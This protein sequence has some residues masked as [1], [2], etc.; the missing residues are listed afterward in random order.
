MS[1]TTRILDAAVA[2]GVKQVIITASV[3]SL[4][5]KDDFWKEITITE[6]CEFSK[7]E[8]KGGIRLTYAPYLLQHTIRRRQKRRSNPENLDTMSTVSRRASRMPPHAIS[9]AHTQIWT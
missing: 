6:G 7:K 5:P 1:G 2:A 8:Q 9:R 3:V 4:V